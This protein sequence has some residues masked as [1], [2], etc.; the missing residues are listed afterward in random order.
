MVG[1]DSHGITRAPWYS[2]VLAIAPSCLSR[3][4]LSLSLAVLSRTILL[5]K[6]KQLRNCTLWMQISHDPHITTRTG[7]HDMSL[8]CSPFAHHYTGNHFVFFSWR[9]W[10]VS[11]HAVHLFI[12]WIQIKISWFY[13]DGFPHSEI[14]GSKLDW[15]LPEAFGSLPPPSSPFDAKASTKRPFQLITNSCWVPTK[16]GILNLQIFQRSQENFYLY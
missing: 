4:R 5:N 2:G 1:A 13:Q 3:T 11:V 9:Y 16:L 7:L 15:Q 10:D 14:F 6:T 8:G 12:L